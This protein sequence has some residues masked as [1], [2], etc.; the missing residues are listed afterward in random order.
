MIVYLSVVTA[1]LGDTYMVGIRCVTG[2]DRRY[3]PLMALNFSPLI[4]IS[5]FLQLKSQQFLVPF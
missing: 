2:Y 5:H 1:D 3:L 4:T